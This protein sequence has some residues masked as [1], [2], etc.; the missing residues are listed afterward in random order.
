MSIRFSTEHR[1]SR[2]RSLG[3]ETRIWPAVLLGQVPSCVFDTVGLNEAPLASVRQRGGKRF[4]SPWS[5]ISYVCLQHSYCPFA[6]GNHIGRFGPQR[7]GSINQVLLELLVE[8]RC[9][10]RAS[11]HHDSVAP[12]VHLL[13]GL[14]EPFRECLSQH[15]RSDNSLS[16][17]RI[18]QAEFIRVVIK[19]VEEILGLHGGANLA[20][21]LA[22]L[23]TFAL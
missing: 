22:R 14:A 4:C 16:V 8:L 3:A 20:Q 12:E 11:D 13:H 2:N 21:R 23:P 5:T 10:R 1:A 15:I 19:Y 9:H 7:V 17:G 6:C 18:E